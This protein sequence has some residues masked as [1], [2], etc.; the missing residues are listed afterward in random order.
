MN[1]QTLTRALSLS[2]REIVF[3]L[4]DS[5][6]STLGAIT[7]IAAGT[8][9]S[10]I[11]ILSGLVIIAVEATSMAAGSYL[12]SESAVG[13]ERVLAGK[14]KRAAALLPELPLRAA[15]VMGVF[16]AL[17]GMVPLIPYLLLPIELAYIPSIAFTVLGLFLT[18]AW[19]GKMTKRNVWRS[20]FEMVSVSLLA[21]AIGYGIGRIVAYKFGVHV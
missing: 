9:S 21:A 11:V 18:G 10:Y 3:G 4:E 13:L 5:F 20:A 17:G 2:I 16:Y 12:S 8:D 6:V 14:H 7:G 1:R 19:V 15:V